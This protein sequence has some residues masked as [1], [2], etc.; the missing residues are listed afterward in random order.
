[1]NQLGKFIKQKRE[2]LDLSLRGFADLCGISHSYLDSIEKGFDARSGKPV[3]PTIETLEKLAAGLNISL[4]GLLSFSGFIDLSGNQNNDNHDDEL[5][6]L[7]R[8]ISGKLTSEEKHDLAEIVR[9]F[10]KSR[11]KK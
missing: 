9:I 4:A 8:Q 2:E 10:V 11:K 6:S 1:M 7:T 5:V 3:S